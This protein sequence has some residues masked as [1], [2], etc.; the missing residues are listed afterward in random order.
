[1]VAGT[2]VLGPPTAVFPGV[3]GGSWFRNGIDRTRTGTL[4]M[5]VG[6]TS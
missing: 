1:M 3:L 2:Q 5:D 6:V 4:I